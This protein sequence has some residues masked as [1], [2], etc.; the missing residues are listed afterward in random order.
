MTRKLK[1]RNCAPLAT[2]ETV[3]TSER[4]IARPTHCSNQGT[5]SRGKW[6]SLAQLSISNAVLST[7]REGEWRCSFTCRDELVNI[8]NTCACHQSERSCKKTMSQIQTNSGLADER[9][10]LK[11]RANAI[12]MKDIGV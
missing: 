3:G 7:E 1:M 10:P 2:R 5:D 8:A 6:T 4:R 12:G 11:L 9:E